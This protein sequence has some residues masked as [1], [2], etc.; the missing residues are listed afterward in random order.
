MKRFAFCFFPGCDWSPWRSS[1]SMNYVTCF[2]TWIHAAVSCMPEI[3]CFVGLL[4]FRVFLACVERA[5][6]GEKVSACPS[7]F[8][9][10]RCMIC[11]YL[12]KE[13][14]VGG[15]CFVWTSKRGIELVLFCSKIHT[16]TQ[17]LSQQSQTMTVW[18]QVSC[19]RPEIF[20]GIIKRL[21]PP[22]QTH[23]FCSLSL[24]WSRRSSTLILAPTAVVSHLFTS[25]L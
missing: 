16:H 21:A 22:P 2:L 17:T 12:C 15:C 10:L 19:I 5:S 14:N 25:P 6:K 20:S 3:L 9:L 24:F 11:C 18:G 13:W 23:T 8:D 1:D 4:V 7:Y